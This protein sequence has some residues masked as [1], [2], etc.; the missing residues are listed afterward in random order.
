M[1][2]HL[3]FIV[4]TLT[5]LLAKKTIDYTIL[6]RKILKL[7]VQCQQNLEDSIKLSHKWVEKIFITPHIFLS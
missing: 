7:G 3:N 4:Q 6:A 5:F 2:M 1:L